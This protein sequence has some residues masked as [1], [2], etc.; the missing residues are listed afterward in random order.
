M[1]GHGTA[2]ALYMIHLSILLN[3]HCN[4]LRNP[5]EFAGAVNKELVNIFGSITTFTALICVGIHVRAETLFLPGPV[6]PIKPGRLLRNAYDSIE[7]P[8]P[9]FVL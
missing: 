8:S 9:E 1:E 2:A 4:L 7:E 3:R 5:T 6:A